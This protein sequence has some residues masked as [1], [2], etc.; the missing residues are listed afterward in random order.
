MSHD[1]HCPWSQKAWV[2]FPTTCPPRG[3]RQVASRPWA[4]GLICHMKMT[5]S[6]LSECRGLGPLF[7]LGERTSPGEGGLERKGIQL[8]FL[9]PPA[10][11][12]AA[13]V[14]CAGYR[15]QY[16]G[17]GGGQGSQCLH[18]GSSSCVDQWSGEL[19]QVRNQGALQ[20]DHRKSSGP[21]AVTPKPS[22]GG[23]GMEAATAQALGSL[24]I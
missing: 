12:P 20:G 10:F 2:L 21:S 17:R 5:M 8:S 18:A 1:K 4:S 7:S 14:Y 9:F 3:L 19:N 11:S 22:P 13:A 6:S 16:R 23:Y 24:R 15:A